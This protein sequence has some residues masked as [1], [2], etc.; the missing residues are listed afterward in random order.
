[1]PSFSKIEAGAAPGGVG[2]SAGEWVAEVG[3]HEMATNLMIPL[4]S[5][6]VIAPANKVRASQTA[7]ENGKG[8]WVVVCGGGWWYAVVGGGMRWWV[9]VSGGGWW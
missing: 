5:A 3:V 8:R 6:K 1:M 9:V 4:T 7:M 2:P